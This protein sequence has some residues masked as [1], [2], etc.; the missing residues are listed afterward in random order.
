VADVPA[1]EASET[2]HL[3]RFYPD[4]APRAEDPNYHLFEQA[5]ARLKRQGLWKCVVATEDCAGPISLHHSHF[6]FAY[7][8]AIDVDKVNE[9]L[10]LH[11]DDASFQEFIEGPGNLEPL[12][13]AHHMGLL[14]IHRIPTADWD[15]VRAHKAG[16]HPVQVAP[17]EGA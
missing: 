7:A 16:L 1:H 17:P 8:N 11:L 2:I 14:A 15:T 12:C 6:E 10:G 4:H 9:L 5:K 13:F 3:D